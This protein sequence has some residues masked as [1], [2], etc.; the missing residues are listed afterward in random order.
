M[1]FTVH[2]DGPDEL[3]VSFVEVSAPFRISEDG[4]GQLG[5]LFEAGDERQDANFA[6][7]GNFH[8]LHLSDLDR[9]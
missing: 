3:D 2:E 4:L 7:L 6:L 9:L 1:F 8:F 5:K